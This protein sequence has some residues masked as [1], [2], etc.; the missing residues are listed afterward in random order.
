MASW[1]KPLVPACRRAGKLLLSLLQSA[2]GWFHHRVRTICMG[3]AQAPL[4]SV[5]TAAAKSSI[6]ARAMSPTPDDTP[7]RWRLASARE[8]FRVA[9]GPSRQARVP[10]DRAQ[11]QLSAVAHRARGRW[12][13]DGTVG[14]LAI[15]PTGET[16]KGAAPFAIPSAVPSVS[17][18]YRCCGLFTPLQL[19]ES[20]DLRGTVYGTV[21]ADDYFT[22][23]PAPASAL[24]FDRRSRRRRLLAS[25]Q[26]S[27]TETTG[28]GCDCPLAGCGKTQCSDQW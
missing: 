10:P 11:K 22:G 2:E 14:S 27:T 1:T 7:S 3:L 24:R 25:R 28:E 19:F 23:V 17:G 13:S 5:R 8:P 9:A 6:T 18:I 4:G 16:P 12:E 20:G 15:T 26:G 21:V